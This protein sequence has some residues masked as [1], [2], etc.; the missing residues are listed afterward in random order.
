[1]HEID[2]TSFP[3]QK[4]PFKTYKILSNLVADSDKREALSTNPCVDSYTARYIVGPSGKKLFIFDVICKEIASVG[5]GGY[6]LC[7]KLKK[8]QYGIYYTH[9]CAC[10][11]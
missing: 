7:K 6:G 8:T 1:M 10:A 2:V 4:N 3:V 11:Q 9:S 5:C